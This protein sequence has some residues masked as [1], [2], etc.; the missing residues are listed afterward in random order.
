MENENNAVTGNTPQLPDI[1]HNDPENPTTINQYLDRADEVANINA[2]VRDQIINKLHTAVMGINFDFNRD[3]LD[4]CEKKLTAATALTSMLDAR[5]KSMERRI[6]QRLR[7]KATEQESNMSKVAIEILKNISVRDFSGN[8]TREIKHEELEEL[9]S[10][11][12]DMP[13][14]ETVTRADPHDL[15]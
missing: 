7:N 10:R 14:A 5:E 13:I 6:T 2:I 3:S 4:D 9:D 11:I 15:S 12:K 8:Q 1:I